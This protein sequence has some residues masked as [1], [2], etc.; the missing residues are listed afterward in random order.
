MSSEDAIKI[1]TKALDGATQ[2]GV[3]TLTEVMTI[4]KACQQ[5]LDLVEGK[6]SEK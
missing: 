6:D 4:G 1:V 5:L 3:F 2:R